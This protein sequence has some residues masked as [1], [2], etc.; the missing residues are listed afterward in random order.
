[1]F[2]QKYKHGYIRDPVVLG[3][4]N[5]IEDVLEVKRQKGFAGIPITDT[6][7]IGGKLMGIIT[8]RCI[9]FLGKDKLKEPIKVGI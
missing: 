9:D 7:K 5:T 6:G 8:S 2:E 4:D 1:M 3:P